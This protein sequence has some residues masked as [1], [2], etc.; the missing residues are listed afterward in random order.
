MRVK[1]L[2]FF[3]VAILVYLKV[4]KMVCNN[5]HKICGGSYLTY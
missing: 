4:G 5:F 2:T 1:M 3:A